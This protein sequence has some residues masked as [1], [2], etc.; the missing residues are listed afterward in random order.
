MKGTR[1]KE[2]TRE[3]LGNILREVKIAAKPIPHPDK[4]VFI[5]GCYNSG[6]TL[7][8]ELMGRHPDMSALPTE[9]HFI[10]D[11]FKKDY[12]L[13]I[14]RMW[15]DREDIFRLTENDEGPDVIRIKK[16]WGMRL[17]L[18][19]KVLVEKSPPNTGRTRWFQKHFENAHFIGI[20]R[21]GYAVAEGIS[22]KGD[23]KAMK[24]GWPMEKS[25][26]QWARSNEIMLDDAKHLKKFHLLRY[27]DL[28][29]SPQQELNKIAEFL[30]LPAFP[31]VRNENFSIHERNDSVK[32]MNQ[33]SISKLSQADISIVN[34]VAGYML[35]RLNYERLPS[36]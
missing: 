18:K 2:V 24:D 10:T 28:A 12:D 31:D 29:S 35:D 19:K 33:S 32:D 9:G 4:W 3:A 22:R 20:V 6:T 23:P 8:S 21:N 26:W 16:E 7:L 5:V 30:S 15:V 14:P 36:E 27:E 11:Q 1:F 34:D 17:N 13:G 25:A